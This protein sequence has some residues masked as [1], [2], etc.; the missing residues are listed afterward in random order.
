MILFI[1]LI[2]LGILG[3]L[4][5]WFWR[6]LNGRAMGQHLALFETRYVQALVRTKSSEVALREALAELQKAPFLSGLRQNETDRI[7]QILGHTKNPHRVIVELGLR[8]TAEKFVEA[9]RR[10]DV[11]LACAKIEETRGTQAA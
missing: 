11:L 6:G 3:V 1:T 2:A 10:E 9:L 4:A 5:Y 8:L 7:V